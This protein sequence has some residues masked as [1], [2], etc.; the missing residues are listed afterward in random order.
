MERS[1]GA[2][3]PDWIKTF[4]RTDSSVTRGLRKLSAVLRRDHQRTQPSPPMPTDDRGYA[5]S[6]RTFEL[7]C[8][9]MWAISTYTPRRY[10]GRVA[11]F[12]AGDEQTKPVTELVTRWK[13]YVEEMDVYATPGTHFSSITTH[14]EAL[15]ERMRTWLNTGEAPTKRV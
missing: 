1:M 11:M 4:P 10:R 6:R 15:A 9:Y 13:N 8:R 14:V 7:E 5:R 2:Q 3:T 12:W